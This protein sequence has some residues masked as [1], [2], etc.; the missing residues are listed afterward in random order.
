MNKFA[1]GGLNER[2]RDHAHRTSTWFKG[3]M[4]YTL[5]ER[6]RDLE[7]LPS[8]FVIREVSI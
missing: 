2:I 5:S 8:N 4:D 6:T 3:A 7:G 1:I